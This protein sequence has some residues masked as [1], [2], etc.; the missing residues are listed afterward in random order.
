[1]KKFLKFLVVVLAVIFL[2]ELLFRP[3]PTETR[4][5][6]NGEG[7]FNP[8]C[9]GEA[10]Y[11]RWSPIESA[12]LCQPVLVVNEEGI[13]RKGGDYQAWF[14]NGAYRVVLDDGEVFWFKWENVKKNKIKFLPG[15][16]LNQPFSA[17][18]ATPF[19]LLSAK[20]RFFLPSLQKQ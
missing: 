11:E 5:V 4:V 3:L 13:I 17:I 1:M 12:R 15:V 6:V 10:R 2:M 7:Y 20:K 16:A 9:H 19:F 8:Y 18:S 14:L